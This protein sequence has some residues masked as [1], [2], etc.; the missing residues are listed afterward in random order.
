MGGADYLLANNSLNMGL[1]E[2][3]RLYSV[4]WR[5]HCTHRMRSLQNNI[6]EN[7]SNCIIHQIANSEKVMFLHCRAKNFKFI[8][9]HLS[10]LYNEK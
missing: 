1:K 9:F 8:N 10:E 7:N 4:S 3:N 6:K 5:K 2:C